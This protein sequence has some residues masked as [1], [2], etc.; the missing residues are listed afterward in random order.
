MYTSLA[1][2]GNEILVL[3]T[4]DNEIVIIKNIQ[5]RLRK[6]TT[7]SIQEF[8]KETLVKMF[9]AG[10]I[11]TDE[12]KNLRNEDYCRETFYIPYPLIVDDTLQSSDS[13][14]PRY[15]KEQIDG[16]YVC[17]QWAILYLPLYECAW[18]KYIKYISM[19]NNKT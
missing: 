11:P 17:S 12:M 8:I 3:A 16:H 1:M 6:Y 5:F 14:Y 13:R 10:L 18:I 9:R 15:W 2:S 4:I 7:Q 19:L